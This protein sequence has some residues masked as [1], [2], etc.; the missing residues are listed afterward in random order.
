MVGFVLN[1][2]GHEPGGRDGQGVTVV[3]VAGDPHGLVAFG[4]G[5]HLGNGE[6]PFGPKLGLLPH[7]L[8]LGVDD[9]PPHPV[10]F[11]GAVED[12]NPAQHPDLVGGEADTTSGVH[13]V[14]HVFDQMFQGVVKGGDFVGAAGEH[15]ITE[16]SNVVAGHVNKC[17]LQG[18]KR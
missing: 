17:L 18:F 6:A 3:V 11:G 9:M 2:P 12:E 10:F 8:P 7:W 16:D 15:G 13:G 4:V 5:E 14:E 1:T